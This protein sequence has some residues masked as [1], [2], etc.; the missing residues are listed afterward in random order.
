MLP[1]RRIDCQRCSATYRRPPADEAD[2]CDLCGSRGITEFW[3]LR[4]A[5]AY[6]IVLGD[7]CQP[8]AHELGNPAAARPT[9]ERTC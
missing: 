6:W 3:P 9:E 5:V 2:R 7:T 4:V 1:V 8:C